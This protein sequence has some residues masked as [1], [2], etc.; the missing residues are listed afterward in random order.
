MLAME[1]EM[2]KKT[3]TGENEKNGKEENLNSETNTDDNPPPGYGLLSSV[4]SVAST[5]KN[6]FWGENQDQDQETTEE[7][8]K[9][10]KEE[11]QK[12]FE[13]REDDKLAYDPLGNDKGSFYQA[14]QK[15]WLALKEMYDYSNCILT[16][17]D[18]AVVL[19]LLSTLP[20]NKMARKPTLYLHQYPKKPS[21]EGRLQSRKRPFIS[22]IRSSQS[23]ESRVMVFKVPETLRR[24]R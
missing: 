1:Q 23:S 3:E 13:L 11:V 8:E 5:V 22:R 20:G 24:V 14:S 7:K 17:Q 16:L 4:V 15:D 10:E 9:S 21:G 19:R 6:A 12:N 2:E 18:T